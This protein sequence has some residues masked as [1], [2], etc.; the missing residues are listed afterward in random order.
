MHEHLS[1]AAGELVRGLLRLVVG[2]VVEHHLAAVLLDRRDLRERR[3]IGHHRGR[4]DAELARREGEALRV[5]AR[6]RRHHAGRTLGVA[7]L[8]QPVERAT[9]LE[10]AGE[11]K[12]LGLQD[13]AHAH[14]P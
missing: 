12:V 4:M 8:T 5:I 14:A 7:E 2:A 3:T 10:R 11:L 1:L 6:A 13:C 9:Y